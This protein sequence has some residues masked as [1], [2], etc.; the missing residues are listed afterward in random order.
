MA[1]F[2]TPM[3]LAI[4]T[5]LIQRILGRSVKNLKLDM[6]NTL[7]WGGVILLAVEHVWHGEVVPWPPFLTAMDNPT[8]IPLILNELVV[9]GV[10]MSISIITLWGAI[11]TF[12]K[13]IKMMSTS[14]QIYKR[15]R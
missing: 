13:M 8:N 7:L 10:P 14:L 9:V 11:V 2:I 4:I 1:C 5:T 15:G 12:P 3:I 6:L